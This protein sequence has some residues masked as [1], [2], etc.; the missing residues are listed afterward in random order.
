MSKVNALL[1]AVTDPLTHADRTAFDSWYDEVQIPAFLRELPATRRVVRYRAAEAT[2]SAQPADHPAAQAARQEY[3]AAYELEFASPDGLVDY[4]NGQTRLL[5]AKKIGRG[6]PGGWAMNPQTA[7]GAYYERIGERLGPEDFVAGSVLLV[8]TGPVDAGS[9]DAFER[10]Y[11][12]RRLRQALGAPGIRRV[13]LYR[14]A[15]IDAARLDVPMPP[16]DLPNRYLAFY[17]LDAASDAAL[18]EAIGALRG[19]SDPAPPP[20]D[21]SRIALRGYLRIGEPRT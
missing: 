2:R 11:L 15:E 12:E 16:W 8:H 4:V 14:M 19:M 3:L 20:V 10:W 13:A 5:A 6:S 7:R 18:S 21:A 17:E 1:L 9:R